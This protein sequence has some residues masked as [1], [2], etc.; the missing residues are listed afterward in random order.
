MFWVLLGAFFIGGAFAIYAYFFNPTILG[1]LGVGS[2]GAITSYFVD[3]YSAFSVRLIDGYNV[4]SGGEGSVANVLLLIGM[5]LMVL[6]F[7]MNGLVTALDRKRNNFTL[8]R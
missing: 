1:S 8:V 3:T 4:L 2:C 6:V 5:V 7:A